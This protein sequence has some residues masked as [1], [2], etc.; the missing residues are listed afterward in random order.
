MVP[1]NVQLWIPSIT[2]ADLDG[3]ATQVAAIL[4][5]A[6]G[7][8]EGAVYQA[9]SGPV[10][11]IVPTVEFPFGTPLTVQFT[12][13]LECPALVTVATSWT[14][15][16]GK[17]EDMPGG[18]VA[19]VT[20]GADW[21]ELLPLQPAKRIVEVSEQSS[22]TTVTVCAHREERRGKDNEGL[23]RTLLSVMASPLSGS[24]SR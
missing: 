5:E 19:T 22:T 8:V 11:V 3:S 24:G 10:V 20:A 6:G 23:C 7:V 4:T 9:A 2:V 12:A 1:F 13:V 17:T 15:P 16:P 14:I 21:D 18:F